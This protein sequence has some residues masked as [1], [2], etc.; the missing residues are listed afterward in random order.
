M[1]RRSSQRD[2]DRKVAAATK[3]LHP[4]IEAVRKQHKLGKWEIVR[5]LQEEVFVYVDI[6]IKGKKHAR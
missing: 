4:H 5:L 1:P 2:S 3:D 6:A